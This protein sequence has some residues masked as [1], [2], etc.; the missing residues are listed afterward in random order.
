MTK[1]QR[2]CT[3]FLN[4]LFF[5]IEVENVQEVNRFQEMT[6]IPLAPEAV[7]GLI[8][9]RG[10]VV[11]AIRLKCM[12]ALADSKENTDPM[13]V[14]IQSQEGIFSFIVDDI[15]EV[16]EVNDE[17]LEPPPDTLMGPVREII[18]GAYKVEPNLLLALD[19]NKILNSPAFE[20]NTI[21]SHSIQ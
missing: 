18:R 2:F 12:L 9:L 14:V 7:C 11:T 10:Q 17:L 19:A 5:G 8:N 15:G 16:L 6:S 3:F 20:L 13:N 1:N 4:D 21:T